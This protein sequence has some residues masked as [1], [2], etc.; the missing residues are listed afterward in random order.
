METITKVKLKN[1]IYKQKKHAKSPGCLIEHSELTPIKVFSN[2]FEQR[3]DNVDSNG[4]TS[5]DSEMEDLKNQSPKEKFGRLPTL[6]LVLENSPTTSPVKNL[7]SPSY[8]QNTNSSQ[9]SGRESTSKEKVL[10]KFLKKRSV[11]L[12][13]TWPLPTETDSVDSAT[14]L[15]SS[16]L[17]KQVDRS[18]ALI[19]RWRNPKKRSWQKTSWLSSKSSTVDRWVE[20]AIVTRKEKLKIKQSLLQTPKFLSR[21][22]KIYPTKDQK[23]K[24]TKYFGDARFTYNTCLNLANLEIKN[25]KI[26]AKLANFINLRN[27]VVTKNRGVEIR[28]DKYSMDLPDEIKIPNEVFET[29]K[30][31]R[32]EAVK[33]FCTVYNYR[34]SRAKVKKKINFKLKNKTKKDPVQ[35]ITIPSSAVKYDINTVEYEKKKRKRGRKRK[36]KT[37]KHSGRI[38]IYKKLLGELKSKDKKLKTVLDKW[39]G[40]DIKLS[41]DSLDYWLIFPIPFEQKKIKKVKGVAGVDPGVRS[42]ITVYNQDHGYE[43][44]TNSSKINKELKNLD[45]RASKYGNSSVEYLRKSRQIRDS[46]NS[47]DIKMAKHLVSENSTIIMGKLDSQ[48]LTDSK[49]KSH[50]FNRDMTGMT[51]YK[52]RRRIELECL[53]S[54]R[55]FVLVGEHWTSKT[56]GSCGEIKHD[57]GSTK[58][59]KCPAC[60]YEADR[61]LNA[62]R[63]MIFQLLSWV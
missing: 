20:D 51:H 1:S 33:E 60:T 26:E 49:K 34:L 40:A 41:F 24:L 39:K 54:S 50:K 2:T 38:T 46:K 15:S 6:E 44:K 37:K 56:C 5:S 58:V 52:L 19:T 61:D 57:L 59:F 8:T 42:A 29:P 35:T 27:L 47:W 43:Y 18:F 10:E 4:L 31:I 62:A 48:A 32:A 17:N 22:I 13:S 36:T 30:D 12:K 28:K 63:N 9:I 11:E 16:L 55:K 23:L 3:E 14:N 21:K 45:N 7:I 25:K 53:K